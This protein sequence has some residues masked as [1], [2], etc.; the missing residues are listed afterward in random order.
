MYAYASI[1]QCLNFDIPVQT[2]TVAT[3]GTIA[4][5][6]LLSDTMYNLYCY[7]NGKLCRELSSPS[8]K[9]FYGDIDVSK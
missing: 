9:L 4:K 2:H 3:A 7:L 5:K 6:L 1:Y 8:T